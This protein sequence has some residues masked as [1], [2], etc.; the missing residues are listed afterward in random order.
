MCNQLKWLGDSLIGGDLPAFVTL[1]CADGAVRA[2]ALPDA[3]AA[4][5][6]IDTYGLKR[7]VT[8][9]EYGLDCNALSEADQAAWQS[10]RVRVLALLTLEAVHA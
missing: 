2:L 10:H 4:A 9:L 7:I 5:D 6:E 3:L 8:A 1:Q